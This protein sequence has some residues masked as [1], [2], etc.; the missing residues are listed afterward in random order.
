MRPCKTSSCHYEAKP[1]QSIILDCFKAS[2][3][4]LR[5]SALVESWR[6]NA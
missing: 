6:A 3:S 1:K 2:T 5:D 4:S